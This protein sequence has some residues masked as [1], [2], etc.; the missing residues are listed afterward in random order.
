MWKTIGKW[1]VL[2]ILV[3]YAVWASVWAYGEAG[4]DRCSG[5][6]VQITGAQT[7][8]TVTSKGVVAELARINK[9]LIGTPLRQINTRHI[10]TLLNSL[11]NFEDVQC[12]IT[13]Q[14]KL[15]V[16]VLPMVPEMRVFDGDKSYYINKDGKH[17]NAKAAF[18]ADVPVV[19]G[20]FSSRFPAKEIIPVARFIDKDPVLSQLISMI[21]AR[22]KNNIILIP[23]ISGH[24]INIGDTTRLTEKRRNIIAAYRKILP[25]KGW[26]TYDTISVKFHGQIVATRRD[27]SALHK[28]V[29]LTEDIDAEEATLD[30]LLDSDSQ[31]SEQL[32]NGNNSQK[33]ATSRKPTT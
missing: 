22:D 10:E 3:A 2:T 16:C 23:R 18:Y 15:R 28:E 13:S 5:I 32:Q 24:V 8:D 30:G 31:P 4:N 6:E 27:K 25:Y 12:V 29:P 26:E 21:E 20:R 11:S 17:I 19:S 33:T 1:S 7:V 14:G 9:S